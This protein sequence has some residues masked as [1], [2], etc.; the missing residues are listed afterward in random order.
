MSEEL[1]QPRFL[2]IAEVASALR[3][4]PRTV[5]RRIKAG[6][7]SKVPMEGRLVRVSSD[8]LER[9]AGRPTRTKRPC[10]ENS[11]DAGEDE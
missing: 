10:G 11:Q 9:L 3:V 4:N 2:M 1:Q 8:E 6:T 7:I 5:R